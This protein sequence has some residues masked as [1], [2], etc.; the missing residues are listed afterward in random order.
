[1]NEEITPLYAHSAARRWAA[2]GAASL[3]L[4]LMGFYAVSD[5]AHLEQHA[6][7]D[8]AD[9]LGYG[10]CHRLPGH[11][12]T[13]AGRPFP[14]CARC[15]GMYLGVV[16]CLLLF[17]LMGRLRRT[18]LPPLPILLTLIGFIGIMGVDGV[19]SM[20]HFLPNAPHLYTPQ[21]WLR[22][23]T[24]LGTGLAM[25]SILLPALA[26]T[27]WRQY[28]PL[29]MLASWGDLRALL[30]LAGAALL[31]ALSNQPVVLYVLA[32]VSTAGV[33]LA[34]GA[35]NAVLGLILLRQDGRAER[36]QET[37]VPL[38]LSLL[39]AIVELS[40]IGLVRYQLTGTMAGFS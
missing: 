31:L 37:A 17:W 26:Q 19:N 1:M 30:L 18:E 20:L 25:G 8:G 39:L 9:W 21:N 4:A 22:L 15:T 7:L 28:T 13:I 40:A 6:L 12:L 14:L 3:G 24:G 27:L 34:L 35:I 5:A 38:A 32:L 36:W 2:V 29:P 11:S 33:L 16:L 23:L 10:I